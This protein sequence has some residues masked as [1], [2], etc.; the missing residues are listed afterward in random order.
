MMEM[1]QNILL[2][3]DEEALRMTLSDRLHS[4]GYAV[5]CARDGQEGLDKAVGAPHD[6]ILLD[7]MLPGKNGFDVCRE[8]REAGLKTPII[9]LTARGETVDKIVGLKLGADDYVAKP[10]DMMELVA[11]VEAM[12]RRTERQNGHKGVVQVGDIR[13]DIRGTEVTRKGKPVSLSA[14][15]FQL[16]RYLIEHRGV[17]LPRNKILGEVWG[18]SA[19]TFTRTVDVHIASLRQKVEKDPKRPELIHTVPGLGYKFTA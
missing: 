17:T 13:V 15:E 4:E 9:M 11:R 5:E 18:Y 10:F 3:E 7:V 14:R 1:S 16:L 8:I 6:L 19:D 2:I 12:L